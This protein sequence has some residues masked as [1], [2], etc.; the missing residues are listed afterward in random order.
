L[1]IPAFLAYDSRQGPGG[2]Q[3][4][5]LIFDVDIVDV[6]DAPSQPG[7]NAKPPSGLPQKVDPQPKK[8]MPQPQH[9]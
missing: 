5:N 6:R 9:K 1:Y 8:S 3:Y 4:E 7:A 2:K